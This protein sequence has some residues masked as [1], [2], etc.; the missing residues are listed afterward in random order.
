MGSL[1]TE[2]L[3]RTSWVLAQGKDGRCWQAPGCRLVKVKAVKSVTD[4]HNLRQEDWATSQ[5]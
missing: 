1:G 2:I 3:Q 5:V 4:H